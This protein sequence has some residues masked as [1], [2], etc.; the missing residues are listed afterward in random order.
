MSNDHDTKTSSR[1]VEENSQ[2]ELDS[3]GHLKVGP[4]S[5]C[6]ANFSPEGTELSLLQQNTYDQY[7]SIFMPSIRRN[8]SPRSICGPMTMANVMIINDFLEE[9]LSS[10]DKELTQALLDEVCERLRNE[11]FVVPEVVSALE[12][13]KESRETYIK[14]NV[15]NF[16]TE[17]DRRLYLSAWTANYE[18]SDFFREHLEGKTYRVFFSRYNQ[19]PQNLAATYEEAIR[20]KEEERFGNLRT[21]K[22]KNVKR[23]ES[24]VRFLMEEF[25]P[26]R[27]LLSAT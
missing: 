13:L 26:Q 2:T 15:S 21:W 10:E 9:V 25:H 7:D 14:E 19:W 16:K 12:W 23:D 24:E 1:T 22:R 8:Q 18:I 17:R 27:R 6:Y 4:A 11:S 20:L 5:D 3:I